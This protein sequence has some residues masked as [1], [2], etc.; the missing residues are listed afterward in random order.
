MSKTELVV[1]LRASKRYVLYRNTQLLAYLLLSCQTGNIMSNKFSE[2]CTAGYHKV[3]NTYNVVAD[4]F[5]DGRSAVVQ[6]AQRNLPAGYAN[7][8][9]R[10]S[11][12]VPEALCAMCSFTGIL[13]AP[14]AFLSMGKKCIPLL[15]IIKTLLRG[16]L[17][18]DSLGQA[19]V[20]SI[21]NMKDMFE[22]L[23][24]PALLVYFVV[25]ATLAFG[26]GMLTFNFAKMLYAS[27]VAVPAAWL[28]FSHMWNQ[29]ARQSLEGVAQGATLQ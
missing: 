23:I 10:I 25:D 16:E 15:P 13:T 21:S 1:Y 18:K 14:A 5:E 8:I 3:V 17:N 7:I 9:E 27:T 20:E 4:A 11:R 19:A 26:A 6:A 22:N 24:L 28:A 2:M 12:A 29:P